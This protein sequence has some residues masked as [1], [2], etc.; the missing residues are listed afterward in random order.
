M[1]YKIL[2]FILFSSLQMPAE[3]IN[4]NKNTGSFRLEVQAYSEKKQTI[5]F[6][7]YLD[8][9]TTILDSTVVSNQGSAIFSSKEP[10]PVGQY[11]IYIKNPQIKLELLLAEKQDDIKLC[12][13]VS[14]PEKSTIEGSND[15]RLFW[16]YLCFL[17]DKT[18]EQD[19]LLAKLESKNLT[20]ADRSKAEKQIK[21]IDDDINQ[22]INFQLKKYSNTWF[23]AYLKAILNVDLALNGSKT[24]EDINNAKAYLK[25]HYFDNINLS[26]RRYW[27]T[28]YFVSYLEDYMANVVEQ[29]PD[30]LAVSACM[31]VAKAKDDE[32]CFEK[33]LTRFLSR[34][35]QSN[36]MGDENVWML[37]YEKYIKDKK[38]SWIDS[39]RY[40]TLDK[41]YEISANCRVGMKA[42]NLN[43][44]RLEGGTINTNDI[45]SDYTL[46]YFYNPTCGHCV[47]EIPRIREIIEDKYLDKGM[48]VV[49]INLNNDVD[50]WKNF[51]GQ[52]HIKNWIN[53][54]DTKFKSNYWMYYDTSSTPATYLLNKN[55]IIVAK[56]I[57]STNLDK[58]LS[59]YLK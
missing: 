31:L 43:L 35:L 18:K 39:S 34:S 22:Y 45:D 33:M 11:F 59:Y 28:N 46:L 56:M 8:G 12:V 3:T 49:G 52:M 10:Y 48:V 42:E 40:Q 27:R 26:D 15:T 5:Y 36:V 2:L 29:D 58:F 20:N 24:T 32:Y 19:G 47:K 23:A 14:D 57:D 25:E 51:V 41:L 4:I 6:G 37:L 30:S 1:K 44:D 38:L 17:N 13:N 54:S 7:G 16:A 50:D 55:K 21:K 9:I 53:C